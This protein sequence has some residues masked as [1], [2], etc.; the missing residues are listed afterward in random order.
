[1]KKA[2]AILLVAVMALTFAACGKK[3]PIVGTWA[4]GIHTW[5]FKKD[6]T[7]TF[8]EFGGTFPMTY[9]IKGNKI[10]IDFGFETDEYT[11]EIKGKTL[12]LTIPHFD[13]DPYFTLTKQ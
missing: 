11:F 1:M 7:G 3:S 10:T 13:D 6:G 2:V 9:K 4:D 12:M 5:T 8:S